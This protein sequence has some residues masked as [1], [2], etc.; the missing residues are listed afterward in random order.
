LD[1]NKSNVESRRNCKR[2]S[3]IFGRVA[4]AVAT[5][6]VVVIMII[7]HATF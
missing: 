2:H 4:V 5:V 3:K 6:V 1:S 7:S